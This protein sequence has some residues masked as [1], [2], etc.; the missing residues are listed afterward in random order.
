MRFP[1]LLHQFGECLYLLQHDCASVYKASS[2]RT[3]FDQ[4]GVKELKWSAQTTD[5]NLLEGIVLPILSPVFFFKP[6]YLTSPALYW[7]IGHTFPQR[8]PE[9]LWI[10]FPEVWR[11]LQLHINAQVFGMGR[12]TSLDR[13]DGKESTQCW[14]YSAIPLGLVLDMSNS[15]SSEFV[16]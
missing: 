13:H 16:F 2:I 9:I 1:I 12:P 6:P 3:W 15:F 7:P 11:P 5:L 4:F 8:H 14:A 10:S